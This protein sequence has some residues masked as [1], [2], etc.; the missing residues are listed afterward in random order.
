M[1][2]PAPVCDLKLHAITVSVMALRPLLES[3]SDQG[4][5]RGSGNPVDTFL[6]Q[7]LE[8]SE[9]A[10]SEGAMVFCSSRIGLVPKEC[11]D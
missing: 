11:A 7:L 4:H 9:G 2:S 10:T 5:E 8:T 6:R 1:E 3:A